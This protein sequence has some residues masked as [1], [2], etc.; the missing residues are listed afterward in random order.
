[1]KAYGA[2]HSY[3]I[4]GEKVPKEEFK[5]RFLKDKKKKITKRYW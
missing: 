4:L 3:G 1:M 5:I 2:H